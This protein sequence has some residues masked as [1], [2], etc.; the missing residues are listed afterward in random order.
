MAMSKGPGKGALADI[1]VTPLV[2][3]ML[4]LLVVFMVTTPIIVEEMKNEVDIDLPTTVSKPVPRSELQ[5]ILK[6]SKDYTVSLS[7]GPGK[8]S[9]I[10]ECGGKANDAERA[11]CLGG[12]EA[13]LK[14]NPKMQELID[15]GDRIFF[16]AD[17]NLPYGFVVDVMARVRAAGIGNLGMVTN[18]PGAETAGAEGP[19]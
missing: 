16:M 4:V 11:D 15:S 7:T 10:V 18:P 8:D 12:L 6:L 19:G 17:R 3:V 14:A 13:H 1:N 9:P 2:D 5:T